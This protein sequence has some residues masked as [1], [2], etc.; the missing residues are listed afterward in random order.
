M[1]LTESEQIG[2]LTITK[3]IHESV[4]N[5]MVIDMKFSTSTGDFEIPSDM[6][7]EI[8]CSEGK[9]DLYFEENGSQFHTELSIGGIVRLRSLW[10]FKTKFAFRANDF[11]NFSVLLKF[12]DKVDICLEDSPPWFGENMVER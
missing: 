7:V 5:E 4:S 9:G 12:S 3:G 10:P 2:G 8:I 11:S 6:F 1:E